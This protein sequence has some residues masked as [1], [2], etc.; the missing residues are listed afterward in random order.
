M[1]HALHK[2]LYTLPAVP[3]AF[4]AGRHIPR[5]CER[6]RRVKKNKKRPILSD[7]KSTGPARK[8]WCNI[9][10]C[11]KLS[12]LCILCLL[13]EKLRGLKKKE[14][15]KKS[16]QWW[17]EPALPLCL[18]AADEAVCITNHPKGKKKGAYGIHWNK[19]GPIV[20]EI[21]GGE[22]WWTTCWTVES[23]N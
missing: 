1:V 8:E 20:R 11:H 23:S 5:L 16:V 19:K 14:K 9:L 6:T 15:K 7:D 21:A 22:M 10:N 12:G 13:L 2:E 17:T 3:R 4:R 18:H